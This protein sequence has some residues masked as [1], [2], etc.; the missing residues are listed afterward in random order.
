MHAL[1]LKTN[2]IMNVEEMVDAT[3]KITGQQYLDGSPAEVLHE[4]EPE[5][6]ADDQTGGVL[7]PKL[8]RKARQAE[9]VYLREMGVYGKVPIEEC[10]QVTDADPIT[11]RWVDFNK[12]RLGMS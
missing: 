12:G 11:V 2:P 4:S 1:G 7:D 5:F 9:I 8:V 3:R 6:D 10:W